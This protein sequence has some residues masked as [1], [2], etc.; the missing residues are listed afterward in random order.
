MAK[1][2]KKI[3]APH[4]PWWSAMMTRP[5]RNSAAEVGEEGDDKLVTVRQER[6]R[7]L[8]QPLSWVIRPRLK[9][10]ARL[11]GLSLEI[12]QRCDGRRRVI[13]LADEFA[14]EHGLTFHEARVS[15]SDYLQ[16]LMK[17]GLVA[18]VAE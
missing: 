11:E 6:P 16:R 13:E 10:T 14:A 5:V 9:K 12:W 15:V 3:I 7:W 17:R 18:V 2:N 8:V 1:K 4:G